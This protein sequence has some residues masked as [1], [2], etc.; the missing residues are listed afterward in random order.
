M[1]STKKQ[2]AEP[3]GAAAGAHL[4]GKYLNKNFQGQRMEGFTG[5]HQDWICVALSRTSNCASCLLSPHSHRDEMK[6]MAWL[7]VTGELMTFPIKRWPIFPPVCAQTGCLYCKCL[8][9]RVCVCVREWVFS[10]MGE[11]HDSSHPVWLCWCEKWCC[12]APTCTHVVSC[13][14]WCQHTH[15]NTHTHTLRQSHSHVQ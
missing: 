1:V 6:I 2:V 4:G 14:V 5:E 7:L 8:C 3:C 10:Q 15:T 11:L 9:E 13:P 12:V